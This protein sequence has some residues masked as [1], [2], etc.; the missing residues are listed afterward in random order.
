M[1]YEWN[2][3]RRA[4][5]ANLWHLSRTALAKS[6]EQAGVFERQLWT[7]TAYSKQNPECSSTAAYKELDRQR[8]WR[9]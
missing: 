6:G 3:E 5:L 9:Q 7:A 2:D 8:S 4:Y 1:K